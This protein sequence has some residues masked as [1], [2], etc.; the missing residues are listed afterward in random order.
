MPINVTNR[1]RFNGAPSWTIEY[2]SASNYADAAPLQGATITGNVWIRAVPVNIYGRTVGYDDPAVTNS[3][4]ESVDYGVVWFQDG[5][6]YRDDD[7]YSPFTM[8]AGGIS[9]LADSWQGNGTRTCSIVVYYSTGLTSEHSA[10]FT[11]A[12]P[13]TSLTVSSPAVSI[14]GTT[15]TMTWTSNV[16]ASSRVDHKA[17]SSGTWILGAENATLTSVHSR[18]VV[19][20]SPGVAY[21]FRGYSN[22]GTTT[23]LTATV[24]ATA[25]AV[26]VTAPTVLSGPSVTKT[27]SSVTVA[28]TV[29][30]AAKLEVEYGLTTG[31]GTSATSSTFSSSPT[32]TVTGLAAATLY[33]YRYRLFDGS[34]NYTAWSADATVT[35]DAAPSGSPWLSDAGM[36][37]ITGPRIDLSGLTREGSIT[38]TANGQVI[39]GRKCGTIKVNH[40]DVIIEDCDIDGNPGRVHADAPTYAITIATAAHRLTVRHCNVAGW[41]SSMA[42]PNANDH[43]FGYLNMDWRTGS[44]AFKLAGSGTVVEYC[45]VHD[46]SF[47]GTVDQHADLLQSRKSSG[48]TIRYSR[49]MGPYQTAN[50]CLFIGVGEGPNDGWLVHDCFISGGNYCFW[51]NN[52]ATGTSYNMTF[53]GYDQPGVNATPP[54]DPRNSYQYGARSGVG[55][56]SDKSGWVYLNGNPVT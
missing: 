22:D 28:A 24:S 44:D 39:S 26:D 14:A 48:F 55:G 7:L 11:L 4:G 46:K 15:G 34:A 36:I 30:E 10:T 9:V 18:E 50:A 8:A 20:L 3:P 35:T 37:A 1:R 45:Y 13:G 53:D 41:K 12:V 5:V 16:P 25:P 54:G 51:A 42:P 27:A 19:G 2:A 33:H 49:L 32:V 38:T 52:A 17:S 21:D 47:E 40:T 56:V 43:Y 6:I 29:D 23:A 31:Y